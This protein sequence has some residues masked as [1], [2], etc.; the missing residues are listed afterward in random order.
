[1]KAQLDAVNFRISCFDCRL[2]KQCTKVNR[3]GRASLF[4]VHVFDHVQ[5]QS[6]DDNSINFG[7]LIPK[8]DKDTR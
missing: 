3:C 4:T 8:I 6:F 1:M 5:E 2:K 7:G